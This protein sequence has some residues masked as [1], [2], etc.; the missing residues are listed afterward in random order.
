MALILA[1]EPDRKQASKV[2]AIVKNRLHAEIVSG[3]TTEHAV[4]ALNG[5]VPD[6]ILTSLLLSPKDD[7]RLADWLRASDEAGRHVQTLVIPVLGGSARDFRDDDGGGLLSRFTRGRSRDDSGTDGCDPEI[8]ATQ[9]HEY[10]ERAAEERRAEAERR[11]DME[12]ARAAAAAGA[13]AAE[14]AAGRAADSE[15]VY[16]PA[17][18]ESFFSPAQP[19]AASQPAES[20]SWAP[21]SDAASRAETPYFE[22]EAVAS[23]PMDAAPAGDDTPA[24]SAAGAEDGSWAEISLGSESDGAHAIDL[25]AYARAEEDED[26]RVELTSEPIDLQRF[27]EE[28]S[29]QGPAEPDRRRRSKDDVLAEFEDA[30]ETINGDEPE[31]NR[32]NGAS[33]ADSDV[34]TPLAASA[35]WPHLD[36]TV[37]TAAAVADGDAPQEGAAPPPAG[38]R[39]KKK[40]ARMIA[41]QDDWSPFDPEQCGFAALLAKLDKMAADAKPE[42][43]GR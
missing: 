22:V 2:A 33:E 24:E 10:L 34:L 23:E 27:V 8:F 40:K 36:S 15:P 1:I 9:V 42:K 39:P 18:G 16:E 32:P 43:P 35:A 30:L 12:A 3:D 25:P 21:F 6:L 14:A 38:R 37:A 41:P 7:A 29:T 31:P 13:Q 19:A 28:L 4:E 20:T 5:R 17:Y 26:T 11:E